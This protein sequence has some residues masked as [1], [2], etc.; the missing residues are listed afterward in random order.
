MS[1]EKKPPT[2]EE[3][4]REIQAEIGSGD[5][6]GLGPKL[7][8]AAVK[9]VYSGIGGDDW[10]KFMRFFASTE[11]Q[12]LRLTTRDLD[13]HDYTEQARAYLVVN[14]TCLPG[15]DDNMM[16]GI[17]DYLDRTLDDF[18]SLDAPSKEER[19]P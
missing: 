13:C 8:K 14:S 2:I 16:Q 6:K 9:A 18:P 4:I 15:T 5:P 17:D 3:K 11:K 19:K 10:K 1:S 7:Q 12:L